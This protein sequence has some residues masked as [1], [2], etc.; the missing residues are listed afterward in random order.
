MIFLLPQVLAT[1]G[2]SG[3]AARLV[4]GTARQE[5]GE[6]SVM[7]IL[8]NNSREPLSLDE[9]TIEMT[10]YDRE[11]NELSSRWFAFRGLVEPHSTTRLPLGRP[12]PQAIVKT[13]KLHLKN[14]WGRVI[15][16]L[17]IP[18]IPG[19]SRKESGRPTPAAGPAGEPRK[20]QI[21]DPPRIRN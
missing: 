4:S 10:G 15:S 6:Y 1:I 18:A 21:L 17:E 12:D 14:R 11:G 19:D 2:C 8:E 16:E 13:S 9:I 7:V 3:P 5:M 20:L